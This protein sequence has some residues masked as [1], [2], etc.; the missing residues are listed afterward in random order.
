MNKE[1]GHATLFLFANEPEVL[2]GDRAASPWFQSLDGLWKFNWVRSPKDRPTDFY[3]EDF[4]DSGWGYF[5]VPANWEVHGL[6]YPIYLDEKY[7]FDTQWPK[8]PEDYNPVGTY[9]RSFTVPEEWMDRQVFIQFGAIKSALYVW[10]NGQGLGFSED[11]KLPAEFDLTPYLRA[12]EN[13]IAIQIFR[14]SVASYQF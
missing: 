10:V 4:D 11:S 3:R 13:T 12:G 7:P 1:G 8:V 5:P 9:R 14:W 2:R 6:D